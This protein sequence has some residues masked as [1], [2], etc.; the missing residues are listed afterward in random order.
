MPDYDYLITDVKNT[1][2]NDSTEFATQLPKIVNKAENK[3]TTDLD[4]HGL[5]VYTSIAIPSGQA[6]LLFLV[7]LVSLGISP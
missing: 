1:T 4:D 2:E 5:T 7:V 6:L 3:L